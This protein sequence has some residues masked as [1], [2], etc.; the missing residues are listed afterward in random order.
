MWDWTEQEEE[1]EM[2]G[3]RNVVSELISLP[4]GET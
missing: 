3:D 4:I 1:G 2:W